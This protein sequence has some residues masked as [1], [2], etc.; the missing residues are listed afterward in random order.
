M[1]RSKGRAH[2]VRSRSRELVELAQMPSEKWRLN[3]IAKQAASAYVTAT[4]AN[5]VLARA[6]L[7]E[8]VK[9]E[10][11]VA[12]E[13]TAELLRTQQPENVRDTA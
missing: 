11:Y 6:G 13:Q 1:L 9:T 4:K 3:H 8:R 2:A 12:L 10:G 5:E 7:P